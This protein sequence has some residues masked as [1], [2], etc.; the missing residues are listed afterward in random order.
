MMDSDAIPAVKALSVALNNSG[1]VNSL[2]TLTDFKMQLRR[3]DI[4][5]LAN[6]RDHVTL[7][8]NGIFFDQN[9]VEMGIGRNPITGM[10]DQNE[11]AKTFHFI[12]SINDGAGGSRNNRR[13]FRCTDI[14]AVIIQPR[15]FRAKA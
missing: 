3:R 13:A 15:A 12:S 4:P 14:D 2:A 11:I 6:C 1:R 8:D 7:G 5:S 10:T 9:A